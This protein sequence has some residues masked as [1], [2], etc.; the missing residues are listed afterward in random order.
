VRARLEQ[1][2]KARPV[3]A[4][5]AVLLLAACVAIPLSAIAHRRKQAEARPALAGKP[6][7]SD[8]PRTGVSSPSSLPAVLP[9]A[10]LTL[11]PLPPVVIVGP[12]RPTSS[13]STTPPT[14]PPRRAPASVDAE[15]PAAV[16][17]LRI[18]RDGEAQ[19]AYERLATRFPENPAY[20]ALAGALTRLASAECAATT[21]PAGITCPEV[22]R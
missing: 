5:L 11:H 3:L 10:P 21:P 15:L 18:G 14:A 12:A 19:V 6:I 9:S 4:A 1:H 22:K 16:A 7:V 20:A 17:A 2:V 13:S 8:H